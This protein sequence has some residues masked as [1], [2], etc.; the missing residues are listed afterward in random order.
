MGNGL[1]TLVCLPFFLAK[2]AECRLLGGAVS[3][4][5]AKVGAMSNSPTKAANCF[6]MTMVWLLVLVLAYA[7]A[8]RQE[9]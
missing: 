4:I 2:H 7:V 9:G 6:M 3:V 5:K 1:G 8:G